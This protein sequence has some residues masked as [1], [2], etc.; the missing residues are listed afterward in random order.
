MAASWE[1][2]DQMFDANGERS[3]KRQRVNFEL[4]ALP[5]D[6]RQ[7]SVPEILEENKQTDAQIVAE[8]EFFNQRNM[9]FWTR[10]DLSHLR[11]Y[12][13]PYVRALIQSEPHETLSPEDVR[14]INHFDG[15]S[16]E[17]V[18]RAYEEKYLREPQKNERRCALDSQ[19]EGVNIP[20]VGN[21]AFI[22]REFLLPSEEEE[23][24]RTGKWPKE[25]RMCLMCRRK[26]VARAYINVRADGVGVKQD[27]LLQDYRNLVNVEGEYMLKDCIVSSSNVYQGLLDPVVMHTRTSYRIKV[28]DG[29]RYYDQW[30]YDKYFLV[31]APR[32]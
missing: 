1:S 27:V 12:D 24:K 25:R 18:P 19:C 31:Q 5:H 16:V 32:T 13:F 23:H 20:H 6:V 21:N 30:K 11:P 29:V 22:L 9:S 28:V 7:E 8:T 10:N 15:A 3:T 4:R 2:F 17:V 14:R 26:E